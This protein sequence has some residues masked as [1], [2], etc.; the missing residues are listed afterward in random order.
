M[1]IL[2]TIE[3]PRRKGRFCVVDYRNHPRRPGLAMRVVRLTKRGL[4][5][6]QPFT[7]C[8]FYSLDQAVRRIE[9]WDSL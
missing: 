5:K 3:T 4:S 6:R 9:A 8:R 1:E 7:G 2:D